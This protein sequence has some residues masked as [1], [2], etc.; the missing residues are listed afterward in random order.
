MNRLT[1]PSYNFLAGFE[2]PTNSSSVKNYVVF[3]ILDELEVPTISNSHKKGSS[4]L[5]TRRKRAEFGITRKEKPWGLR[6]SY[7]TSHLT[8]KKTSHFSPE[9]I[10]LSGA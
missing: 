3:F 1:N 10:A 7:S 4:K 5:I 9:E 2:V 6:R 8:R